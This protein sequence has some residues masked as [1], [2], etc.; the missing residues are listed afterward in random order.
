MR[1]RLTFAWLCIAVASC[2][3]SGETVSLQWHDVFALEDTILINPIDDIPISR[4][5]KIAVYNGYLYVLDGINRRVLIRHP[6]GTWESL[7]R[8]GSGPGEF[9]FPTSLEV[10]S[11]R[12]LYV[13]DIDGRRLSIFYPTSRG[14]VY[15]NQ[16]S[17]ETAP[18]DMEVL[19]KFLYM[20]NRSGEYIVAKYNLEKGGIQVKQAIKRKGTPYERFVFRFNLGG[21][22]LLDSAKLAILYPGLKPMVVLDTQ[23]V[24]VDTLGILGQR[25]LPPIPD[26]PTTLSPYEYTDKHAKWWGKHWHPLDILH[27][28][29]HYT[30]LIFYREQ[31]KDVSLQKLYLYSSQEKKVIFH[32]EVPQGEWIL[33]MFTGKLYTEVTP[34]E[35]TIAALIRVYRFQDNILDL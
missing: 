27:V 35:D 24:I 15:K 22:A 17:I 16:F 2:T 7:G 6:E 18:I 8:Q 1:Q 9:Q 31:K 32:V 21:M 26:F 28:K 29:D 4:I 33:G 34:R 5:S 20:L 3:S 23:L 13:F 30:A 12:R 14:Y 11:R 19:G 25:G 10:D